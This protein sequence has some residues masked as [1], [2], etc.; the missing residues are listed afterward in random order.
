MALWSLFVEVG[1]KLRYSTQIPAPTPR[2]AIRRLLS[3]RGLISH[4]LARLSK[5]GWPKAFSMR[6]VLSLVPME[7][8]I[9]MYVCQIE[10]NGKHISVILAR[11]VARHAG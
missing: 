6:D 9:N 3:P 2:A 8:L 1:S 11:T 4:D 7:G 10:R 5:S